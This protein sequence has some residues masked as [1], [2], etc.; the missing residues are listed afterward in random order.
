MAKTGRLHGL[1]LLF[2]F[3]QRHNKDIIVSLQSHEEVGVIKRE[4]PRETK[5]KNHPSIRRQL[6][7]QRSC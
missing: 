6:G 2:V 5:K 4:P 1:Q 7:S 3:F